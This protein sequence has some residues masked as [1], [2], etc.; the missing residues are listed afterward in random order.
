MIAINSDAD[1]PLIFR[2]MPFELLENTLTTG[3]LWLRSAEYY[4]NLEDAVRNDASEGI[5]RGKISIG[6][7][8]RSNNGPSVAIQG[9]KSIG[10]ILAPHY[11]LSLHGSSISKDQ[12]EKFGAHTV[13]IRSI[14]KLAGEILYK[15][16]KIIPVNGNKYGQVNYQYTALRRTFHALGGDAIHVDGEPPSFINSYNTDV[17]RKDPV[18][19]FIEQDEWRIVIYT[20]SYLNADPNL[21]LKINVDLN[22]FYR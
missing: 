12:L 1:S 8:I 6:L 22:N 13:G 2:T 10:G 18:L 21:P 9:D 3:S 7:R 14:W 5:N 4:R 11:I 20:E 16:G 19:P 15:A 17:L